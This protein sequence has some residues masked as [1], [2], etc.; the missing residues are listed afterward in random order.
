MT[1]QQTR[2]RLDSVVFITR[3]GKSSIAE[4]LDKWFFENGYSSYV[5]DGDNTRLGINSDLSFTKEDRSE[6]IRRVAEIC[7]LFNDSGTIVIASFISPFEEDRNR[8][9]TIIGIDS[10]IETF[11]D[12]SLETC[13]V[14]DV[15]GLYKLAAEG[16]L[17]N[18]TGVDSPY[19]RP[20]APA[21]H[22]HTDSKSVKKCADEIIGYL[23]S[24]A[25][26][27]VSSGMLIPEISE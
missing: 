20:S 7:K 23:K 24:R 26:I 18:F 25:I 1:E 4:E 8:A 3:E 27:S 14:R 17:K 16:K 22:L 9:A 15:K 21:I 11:V 10:V 13:K 19:E 12:A 6:N 2:W 5:I